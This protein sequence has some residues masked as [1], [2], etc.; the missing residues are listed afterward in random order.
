M[1]SYLFTNYKYVI[2]YQSYVIYLISLNCLLL[3]D[4]I[5]IYNPAQKIKFSIKVFFSK[6]DQIRRKLLIRLHLLKTSLME[7]FIFCAVVNETFNKFQA[8]LFKVTD[9]HA[10]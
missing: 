9:K 8:E 7:N 4:V 2:K 5:T 6:C 3:L 1:N 10:P